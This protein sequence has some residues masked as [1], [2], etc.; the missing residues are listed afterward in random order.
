M[1]IFKAKINNKVTKNNK[2]QINQ[3]LFISNSI[4]I[5]IIRIII[6]KILFV[7]LLN[8]ELVLKKKS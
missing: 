7:S 1:Q 3:Q 5:K 6:R 8:I 2:R 4:M